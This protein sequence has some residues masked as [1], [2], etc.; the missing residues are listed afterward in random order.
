M[1][2]KIQKLVV[3]VEGSM[4]SDP[5]DFYSEPDPFISQEQEVGDITEGREDF[6]P[7]PF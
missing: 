4:E 6:E 2:I 5:I 1:G 3:L 7:G